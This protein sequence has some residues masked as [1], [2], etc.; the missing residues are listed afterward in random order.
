MRTS[1]SF[2]KFRQNPHRVWFDDE[3]NSLTSSQKVQIAENIADLETAV[4]STIHPDVIEGPYGPL[5]ALNSR[6]G[7]VIGVSYKDPEDLLSGPY[8]SY[9]V[10]FEIDP[11]SP[12]WRRLYT[13]ETGRPIEDFIAE[14]PFSHSKVYYISD[15]SRANTPEAKREH[16]A[17]MDDVYRRLEAEGAGFASYSRGSTTRRLRRQ[18]A[19]GR[20]VISAEHRI[21]DFYGPGDDTYMTMGYYV[22]AGVNRPGLI[23]STRRPNPLL[24]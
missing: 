24:F 1:F 9:Y 10:S 15:Q 14:L 12:E 19:L 16:A 20:V 13:S 4:W 11:R 3:R 5:E 6:A 18:G 8:T 21:P 22:P 7:A 23:E 2:A 17:L